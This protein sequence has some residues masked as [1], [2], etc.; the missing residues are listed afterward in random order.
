MAWTYNTTVIRAGRS[1]TNDDG[2]KH[3][4]NWGSWSDEEK[5]AAGLVWVDDP[6][7]FDSRFFWAAGIP[8]VL[9]DVNEVDENG[10]PLLD[11][12]GNQVVTLGLKSQWIA[13]VKEQAGAILALTDWYA[14]R[15]SETQQQIPS[16]VW[17][18]RAAT[19]AYSNYLEDQ[20]NAVADHNAFVALINGTDDSPS[21][22]NTWPEE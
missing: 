21:V 11:E 1:W 9:D 7:P 6:A 14:I 12:N 10:D 3:P 17:N 8:K 15:H 4:S 2:I 13:K 16:D 5:T 18:H 20:I 19:R 22:F